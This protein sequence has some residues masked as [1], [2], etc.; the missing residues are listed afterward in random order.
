MCSD[1][2]IKTQFSA[3]PCLLKFE[4]FNTNDWQEI[5]FS[6]LCESKAIP[7]Q[8]PLYTF[9]R[10]RKMQI[11]QWGEQERLQTLQSPQEGWVLC[12]P[13]ACKLTCYLPFWEV[14]AWN[15]LVARLKHSSLFYRYSK[16]WWAQT[17]LLEILCSHHLRSIHSIPMCRHESS[18]FM[19]VLLALQCQLWSK[20]GSFS[21]GSRHTCAL[22]KRQVPLLPKISLF[23]LLWRNW[24]NPNTNHSDQTFHHSSLA[25]EHLHHLCRACCQISYRRALRFLVS[26]AKNL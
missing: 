7:K 22:F 17:L 8:L 23:L 2:T 14:C 15:C 10:C 5:K 13:H 11:D 16:N 26:F 21:F 6:F 24:D 19:K 18:T 3:R 25:H 4:R 20:L 12:T 1:L 9:W